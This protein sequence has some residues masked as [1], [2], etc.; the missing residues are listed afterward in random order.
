MSFADAVASAGWTTV[1]DPVMGGL[2]TSTI[3][4][5]D[6]ALVFRGVISLDNNG[7]FASMI[8]PTDLWPA[9]VWADRP[10]V[11]L[12][13]RGDGQTYAVQVRTGG[14]NQSYVQRF[15]AGATFDVVLP[16]DGFTPTTRFL[17]PTT[18]AP[19]LDPA[20]ITQVAIYLLDKQAGPFR[21][22]VVA[23]G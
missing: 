11:A 10:G 9:G 20:E 16:F 7:G 15:V 8:S 4:A 6:D 17:E 19:P 23:I 13:G 5:I 18:D 14:S 1:N 3:E 21:L 12:A 2:S 22:E